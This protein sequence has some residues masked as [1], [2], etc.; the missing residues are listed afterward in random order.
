MHVQVMVNSSW[1]C[2]HIAWLWRFSPWPIVLYPPCGVQDFM[3]QAEGDAVKVIT[4][5]SCDS[6]G[7]TSVSSKRELVKPSS[8]AAVRHIVSVG[9]F[10]PEKDHPLQLHAFALLLKELKPEEGEV[11]GAV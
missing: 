1:T 6:G 4:N 8:T 10:R 11:Q 2:G 7:S 3:D 5:S 9:Q